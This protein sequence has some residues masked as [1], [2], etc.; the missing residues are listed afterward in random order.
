M[1][2]Q[3]QNNSQRK[4]IFLL[5]AYALIF[6]AFYAFIKNPR[7]NSKGMDTSAVF[8]FVNTLLDL[9]RRENPDH[10]VVAFDKGG[11]KERSEMYEAYKANRHETPEGII[12]AVPYIKKI[13]E[14]MHIPIVEVE[15]WEADDLI[16]TLAKQA[17][18]DKYDV[19]MVTADKDF[20]QLVDDHIFLYKPSRMGKGIEI[21]DVEKVREKFGVKHPEQVIDFLGM[22][23]D[24]VDNIPGLP[25][26]G[27]KTAKKFLQEFGSMENLFENTDKLKGKMK[28]KVEANKDL[29]LLSKKLATINIHAPIQ[30]DD[31]EFEL[32][33]PDFEKTGEI[34][35]ELEFRRM[36]EQFSKLFMPKN[37]SENT[38]KNPKKPTQQNIQRSLFDDFDEIIEEKQPKNSIQHFNQLINTAE[39][40]K[41]LLEKLLNQKGVSISL[42]PENFNI[43]NKDYSLIFGFSQG[44]TYCLSMTE[45]LETK[46][47]FFRDFFEHEQIDKIGYDL[48]QIY[49]LLRY[50]NIRLKGRLYDNMILHYLINPDTRNE[51]SILAE[52]YLNLELH[53]LPKKQISE[54]E[55]LEFTGIRTDINLALKKYF[56]EEME[57]AKATELYQNIEAPLLRVLGEMELTGIKLDPASLHELSEKLTH[58]ILKL[59]KDIFEISEEQFNIGSPKQLGIV[60]FEKMKIVTQ[61]KKTKTGQYSTSEEVLSGL[62]KQPIVSKVLE[63][64]SLNKLKNTYLDALPKQINPISGRIHTNFNQAIAATGR[65]SSTD[66]NLQNIPIRT[67]LGREVRRA[68]VASDKNH[69]LLAADYSQIELRLIAAL[70]KDPNM[71]QSFRNHEDIHRATAARLFKVPLESVTREQRS[72]AKTVNFGIIYGVSAHGL[73]QQT[74]LSRSEAKKLIDAYYENYPQLRTYIKNQVDY[75]RSHGYVETIFGRRR[76]LNNINSQNA[77]VRSAAERNAVNAP[78]QGSAAD[79]IK[80][81]MIQI[82]QKLQKY[83][84][85]MLLQVHDELVFDVPV[86]EMEQVSALIKNEMEHAVELEIPLI[87]DIGVGDNWLEAH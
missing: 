51:L 59:E 69:K 66:P 37:F 62:K 55:K 72:Q 75:A 76:Y 40:R 64:R 73:S 87:V 43:E 86:N 4:R 81:A 5:D 24:S 16:G 46:L 20:A 14:A 25:G 52:N 13:L 21:W 83:Q 19:F 6:R 38:Q 53:S 28:E 71:L 18:K 7:I 10:L 77:I 31:K 61:A 30:F 68:F 27:E 2:E 80:K 56:V 48:K 65:L 1:T 70:S 63:W 39:S 32:N 23:G 84:T 36:T 33:T 8:G 26:V 47:K 82:Q 42:Y 49:K 85:K 78:I 9:I 54:R 67:K 34:F 3:N 12:I 45:E 22:M 41:I 29:G 57:R 60:L 17:E 15:G 74:D 58:E 79:I 44:K 35:K 11:S 50:Y